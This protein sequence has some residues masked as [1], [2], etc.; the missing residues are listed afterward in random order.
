MN[1]NKFI[2]ELS[3]KT[4]YDIE[5]CTLINNKLEDTILI[6]KRTKEK[7]IEEFKNLLNVNDEEANKIY[8]ISMGILSS[9]LKNKLKHPFKSRD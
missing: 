1:K 4:L 8:E 7:L 3:K 9:G 6:G 5:T 2:Q